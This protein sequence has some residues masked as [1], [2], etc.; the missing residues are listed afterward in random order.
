MIDS[1]DDRRK[2]VAV[3]G[4]IHNVYFG[5]SVERIVIYICITVIIVKLLST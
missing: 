4:N 2:Q 1:T 5:T 3:G